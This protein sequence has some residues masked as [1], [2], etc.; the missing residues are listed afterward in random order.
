M[1]NERILSLNCEIIFQRDFD[2]KTRLT[3]LIGPLLFAQKV[4]ENCQ[5]NFYSSRYYFLFVYFLFIC[6]NASEF[7]NIKT[8]LSIHLFNHYKTISSG[9]G[10][11]ADLIFQVEV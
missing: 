9:I 5:Y 4:T 3:A 6:L 11:V 1:T 7:A 2:F 8:K 10:L